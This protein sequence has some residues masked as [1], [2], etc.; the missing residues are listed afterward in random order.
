MSVFV[1]TDTHF[2]HEKIF[3][4]CN[5]PLD[6]ESQLIR[7][8]QKLTVNDV[9]IHLGDICI[10]EDQNVHD[11]YIKPIQAK[12]I[13]VRGNH[14][15]KSNNWYLRNGWDFVCTHFYDRYF[16]VNV[17]FSHRPIPWDGFFDVNIHG[18]LHD[19]SHKQ[20]EKINRLNL[21]VSLEKNGYEPLSLNQ[22]ISSFALNNNI[23]KYLDDFKS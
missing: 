13:L 21:L 3:E 7:G 11:Q 23:D 14:D 20:E 12:K 18:H 1:T 8:Y 6:Y 4:Y 17:L 5:R 2:N 15:K 9:L 16:G 19:L 10:G 22:L